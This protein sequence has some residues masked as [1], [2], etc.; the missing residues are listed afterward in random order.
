M[1]P[2]PYSFL[3][4]PETWPSCPPDPP[5]AGWWKDPLSDDVTPR[6]YDGNR[7]TPYVCMRTAQKW[8]QIV[9]DRSGPHCASHGNWER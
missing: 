7:W 3:P 5:T 1:A 2:E 9:K 6:Y 8:I 4:M